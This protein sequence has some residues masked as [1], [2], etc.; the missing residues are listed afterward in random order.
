MTTPLERVRALRKLATS[1]NVHEAAAAAALA[2]RLQLE[3]QLSE[4]DIA[5]AR[6]DGEE[7]AYGWSEREERWRSELVYGLAE[8]YGLAAWQ[9]G[10]TRGWGAIRIMGSAADRETARHTATAVTEAIETILEKQPSEMRARASFA[11]GAVEAILSAMKREKRAVR[12]AASPH[13]LIDKHAEEAAAKAREEHGL[14]TY[15]PRQPRVSK[16]AYDKGKRKGRQW[17]KQASKKG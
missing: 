6:D 16:E 4:A 5:G 8:L 1:P 17:A 12:S 3:H 9:E 7:E 2:A 11:L 15:T 13:A 14:E 10:D